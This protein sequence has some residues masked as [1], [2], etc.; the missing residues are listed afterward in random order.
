MMLVT[1]ILALLAIGFVAL[2]RRVAR[3][4]WLTANAWVWTVLSPVAPK[5]AV[6]AWTVAGK[7]L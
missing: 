6:R 3:N 7:D 5:A 1:A 2:A 4:A